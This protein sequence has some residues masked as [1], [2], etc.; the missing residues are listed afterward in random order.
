MAPVRGLPVLRT[1]R[2]VAV[3]GRPQTAVVVR[4][5]A[6]APT[7]N[8]NEEGSREFQGFSSAFNPSMGVPDVTMAKGG[9]M[10]SGGSMGATMERGRMQFVMPTPVIQG[11]KLD[12]G[13]SGGDIGKII[14]NGGGGGDGGGGDDDDYFNENED[15]GEGEGGQGGSAGL[16]FF[17]S[18]IPESYDK[19]SIGAVLAEW[20]KTVQELPAILRQAVTMGLFSSAQ[21]VRFFSMDVRPNVTRTISRALPPTIA[22]DFIG[23]LMADPGFVQKMVLESSFAAAASLW[24]EYRARGERFKDE[25]DLVLINTIGMAAATG[26]TCWLVAPSRSYG[27]IQKF[28]WQQMLDGLPNCVFDVSGPLRQYSHQARAAGFFAK[29]A[30]LSGVGLLTGTATSLL[31]SAAVAIRKKSNPEWEPSVAVPSLQRSSGGLAAYLALN[32]NVRY[33]LIGG[34]DRIL[35][36]RTNFLWTYLAMSGTAR[37]VSNQVG[38]L[39]RP[40]WQGLPAPST[41]AARMPTQRRV[42]KKVSKKVPKVKAAPV[43][44]EQATMMAAAVPLALEGAEGLQGALEAATTSTYMAADG[45]E[46]VSTAGVSYAG[47]EEQA[48]SSHA[49]VGGQ[50]YDSDESAAQG[51]EQLAAQQPQLTARH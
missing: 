46:A 11:P 35:F 13:G 28:P 29:M 42:R 45:Q 48:V 36:D 47:Q 8:S 16:S 27:S 43:S 20:M 38:E 30:E 17:R 22:R 24:Y 9:D 40:W 6:V 32:A 15:D 33:Q 25:L 7:P 49:L 19:F 3:A 51:S 4:N 23:R 21:L 5:S 34:L 1:T 12:D 41:L 2:R 50:G 14:H 39:S 18:I 44:A 10:G 37:L 31:S 26:A